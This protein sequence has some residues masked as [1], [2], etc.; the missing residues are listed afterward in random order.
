MKLKNKSIKKKIKKNDSS[1]LRLT[2]QTH[3]LGHETGNPIGR[4]LKQ[5]I[6]FNY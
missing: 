3:N 4:K 6:K 2:N 5:I 1:Q